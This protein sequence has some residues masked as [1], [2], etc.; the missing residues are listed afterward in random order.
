VSI[1]LTEKTAQRFKLKVAYRLLEDASNKTC[2]I[3]I[4]RGKHFVNF[5]KIFSV[6]KIGIAVLYFTSV[7][8]Y[9][10][11]GGANLNN[12]NVVG[13]SN[14]PV[15]LTTEKVPMSEVQGSCFWNQDWLP[16]RVF[17]KKG[18]VHVFAKAKLDLYTSGIHYLNE[19]GE[20][21]YSSS[22]NADAAFEGGIGGVIFLSPTDTSR[23]ATFKTLG[24]PM[25]NAQEVFAQILVEGKISFLKAMSVKAVK[26]ETDALQ[27]KEEWMFEPRDAYYIEEQGKIQELRSINKSQLF[28]LIE[29][30]ES[31]EGWLKSQHN[32]LRKEADVVAFIAY[33]NS[34]A[35]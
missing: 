3:G 19:K 7:Y 2:S 22:K 1:S 32:K 30:K 34:L 5:P 35:K 23:I 10:Q 28:T 12:N 13:W 27:R 16:A 29:K 4:N 15:N 17:M 9:G 25:V 26:R 14:V 21:R 24:R 20:V 33:R 8:G 6:K 11:G 31:D 18:P